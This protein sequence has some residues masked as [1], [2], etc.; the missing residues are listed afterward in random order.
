M[1]DQPTIAIPL[2]IPDVCVLRTEL[3]KDQELS[4]EVESP[5]ITAV[6]RRYGRTVTEFHGYDQPIQLRHVPILGDVVYIRICPKR[7]RCPYCDD[8]PTTTQRLRWYVPQALHTTAYEHHLLMPLVNNPIE[9]VC[10]KEETSDDVV[11]GMIERW[12]MTARDWA[13]WPPFTV[14]GMDEIALKQ[15]HRDYVVMVTARRST[16]RLIVLAVWPDRTQATLVTWVTT[17]PAP[18]RRQLRTV[19]T[20]M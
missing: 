16:G 7:F 18:R 10:Q 20:A 2:D 4:I 14:R 9:D 15:G 8:P 6:C 17:M 12:M 11:L 3:T 1:A 13:A 5:L 19:C